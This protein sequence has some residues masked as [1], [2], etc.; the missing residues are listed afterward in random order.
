MRRDKEAAIGSQDFETA[1][2]LRDAEVRLLADKARRE[3]NWA[4]GTEGRSS[5][6]KDLARLSA[7]LDR[8]RG[9]VRE[10]GIEPGDDAA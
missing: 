2:S 1:A 4:R 8:L 9:M 3:K 10:R 7:E 6:A 5:L